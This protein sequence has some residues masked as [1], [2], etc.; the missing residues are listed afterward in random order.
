MPI[1]DEALA[2]GRVVINYNTGTHDHVYA[3]HCRA[4]LADGSWDVPF[5]TEV[6]VEDTIRGI[7]ETQETTIPSTTTFGTFAVYKNNPAPIPTEL[8]YVGVV[9]DTGVV[10][11]AAYAAGGTVTISLRTSLNRRAKFVWCDTLGGSV[12]PL[13]VLPSA[14]DAEQQGWVDYIIGNPNI[15][16]IDGQNITVPHAITVNL[17]DTLVRRYAMAENTVS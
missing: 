17:N 16:T 8:W 2:W 3:F 14:F 1:I 4:M 10:P 15:V 6:T 11:T 9:D 7:L 5:G 12:P 13:R